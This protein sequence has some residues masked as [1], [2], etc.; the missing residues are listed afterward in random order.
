MPAQVATGRVIDDQEMRIAKVMAGV[1]VRYDDRVSNP[2]LRMQV[3]QQ[4]ASMPGNVQRAAS[5]PTVA[6]MMQKEYDMLQFQDEQQSV[7]PVT[8]RTGVK[9]NEPDPAQLP[10]A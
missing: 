7:N 2:Q 4:W 1:P 3:L 10:A 9:P 6:E 8:G 5:D